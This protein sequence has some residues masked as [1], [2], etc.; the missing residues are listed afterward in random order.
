MHSK[1]LILIH[2]LIDSPK[3]ESYIYTLF[4]LQSSHTSI[5][6]GDG[7]VEGKMTSNLIPGTTTIAKPTCMLS[8]STDWKEWYYII[9]QAAKHL[10]VWELCNPGSANAPA[11]KLTKPGPPTSSV[12][13]EDMTDEEYNKFEQK[14]KAYLI[15]EKA[16]EA[17]HNKL[18]QIN[19]LIMLSLAPTNFVY[20]EDK[21]SVYE[22]L[23]ALKDNLAPNDMARRM[24]VRTKYQTL[25][26][27]GNKDIDVWIEE[28]TNAL[29]EVEALKLPEMVDG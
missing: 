25:Y 13:L 23:K 20:I 10:D 18:G 15:K 7:K 16:Y 27:I 22:K 24:L 29:K 11:G 9:Q 1:A 17:Q 28:W 5:T 21:D 26:K 2:L 14:E 4:D 6:A 19:N 12:E 8:P 3:F